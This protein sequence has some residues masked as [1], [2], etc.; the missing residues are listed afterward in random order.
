MK[1]K[2]KKKPP[3]LI[4]GELLLEKGCKI[5]R[6]EVHVR[7]LDVTHIDAES[8]M[9]T[10][11]IV[12]LAIKKNQTKIPFEIFGPVPNP[13]KR[14][15]VVASISAEKENKDNK[16]LYRTTQSIPVFREGYPEAV[17]IPLTK[18]N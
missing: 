13:S 6:S 14:Y 2:D 8:D 10:E 12:V 3:L 9:L 4:E 18:I 7:I 15:I 11:L 1:I 5:T 16:T 17:T